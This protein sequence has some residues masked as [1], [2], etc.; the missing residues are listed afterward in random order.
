MSDE[1]LKAL[2]D[3]CTALEERANITEVVQKAEEGPYI[4]LG[5]S[6]DDCS[7]DEY[8]ADKYDHFRKHI[9]KTYFSISDAELRLAL[10]SARRRVDSE[11]DHSYER[12][13]YAAHRA[14]STASKNIE[15]QPWV[16]AALAAVGWVGLGYA[17]LQLPGSIAGG[18][19]GYFFGQGIIQSAR[20]RA[21]A[22][23]RDAKVEL[24]TALENLARNKLKPECFNHDEQRSGDRDKTFDTQ[25]ALHNVR[26]AGGTAN[27]SFKP[28]PLRGT[29]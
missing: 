28:M 20:N 3:Q 5:I 23:H 18:L 9:R 10:I 14:E 11:L 22:I 29:A 17:L 21:Y 26:A 16:L 19:A 13:V 8:Y 7:T 25:F 4:P 27:N 24:Q 6:G 2:L 1:Q 15:S 12:D